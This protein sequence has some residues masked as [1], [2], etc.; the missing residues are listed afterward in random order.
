MWNDKKELKVSLWNA[1]VY[2]KLLFLK[3]SNQWCI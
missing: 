2:L 1:T 3:N